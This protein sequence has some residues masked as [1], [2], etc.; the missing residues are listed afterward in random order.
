L[1]TQVI[2]KIVGIPAELVAVISQMAP[3]LLFGF[4]AAGVLSVVI[5]ASFIERHLGGRGVLASL[6]AAAF[7][8]PL[9]L[10]SCSVIP[11]ATSLRLHGASKAATTAFL[12]SAPQTGVDSILVTFS[13]MG[14][15]FAIFRPIA[16]LVSGLIG[17]I[18]VDVA[19]KTPDSRPPH[20]AE[21]CPYETGVGVGVGGKILSAFTYGFVT[22]PADI[23]KALLV[24]LVVAAFISALVPHDFFA[25]ALGGAMGH[26]VLAM[27]VMMLLGVPVYVCATASVPI[28]AAL[29]AKGVSP[30]AAL[31]FLMT[32]PATNA[33]TIVTVWKVMGRRTG[34]IYLLTVMATALAA[35][36]TLDL[37]FTAVEAPQ[38]MAAAH[39]ILPAWVGSVSAAVLLVVLGAALVRPMLQRAKATPA[40]KPAVSLS[41]SG[42]TCDHCV[43][44]VTGALLACKGVTAARVD[45]K[46]AAAG[47]DGEDLDTDALCAAVRG[48]GYD[49]SVSPDWGDANVAGRRTHDGT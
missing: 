44:R 12:I 43:R 10:C 48:A 19:D 27:L 37:I 20:Q 5:S 46:A 47:V 14:G 26:G 15:V 11:V 25:E 36:L 18:L 35:G 17:G 23:G 16:A 21:S 42:M 31:A 7:G 29:M 22:L 28:A 49:C 30:G 2:D 9:P 1:P 32:G 3:Y 4:L 8:V 39:G 34:A 13:L 40:A 38:P 41:I 6:K 33:A 45:L 24:G